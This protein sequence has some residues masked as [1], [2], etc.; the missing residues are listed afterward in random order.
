[1][2]YTRVDWGVTRAK[3]KSNGQYTDVILTRSIMMG[4]GSDNTYGYS[5]RLVVSS[6]LNSGQTLLAS[7][8]KNTPKSKSY[9]IGLSA[10]GGKDGAVLGISATKTYVKNVL[11]V[12]NETNWPDYRPSVRFEYYHDTFV[13]DN[14]FDTYCF[15][16]NE[17]LAAYSLRTTDSKYLARLIVDAQFKIY[18]NPPSKTHHRYGRVNTYASNRLVV[19]FTTPY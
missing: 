10:E 2:G 1:M 6:F 11:E 12:I 16:N 4:N 17:Q 18:D 5:D 8:P 15:G 7:N 9:T 19:V 3:Q 13:W 14:T